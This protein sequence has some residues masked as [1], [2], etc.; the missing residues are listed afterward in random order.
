VEAELVEPPTNGSLVEDGE[1][2]ELSSADEL[3]DSFKDDE[4]ELELLNNPRP[5][6][7]S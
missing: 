4:L 3:P 1:L 5:D 7:E 2:L 6:K